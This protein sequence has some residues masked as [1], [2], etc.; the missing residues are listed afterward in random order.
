MSSECLTTDFADFHGLTA[1]PEDRKIAES[2]EKKKFEMR[3]TKS[4]TNSKCEC[5]N[6][7]NKEESRIAQIQRI[8]AT[9]TQRQKESGH[10]PT[11]PW[12]LT[13]INTDEQ[14]LLNRLWKCAYGGLFGGRGGDILDEGWLESMN[15]LQWRRKIGGSPKWRSLLVCQYCICV[16]CSLSRRVRAV[17]SCFRRNDN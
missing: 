17:D 14:G 12:G 2:A 6:G 4:E 5:S 16:C 7:Q 13:L 10:G 1:S 9:K 3:S 15:E 8:L 11:V